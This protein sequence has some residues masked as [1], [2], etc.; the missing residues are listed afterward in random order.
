MT[1]GLASDKFSHCFLYEIR[2]GGQ[3]DKHQILY[4]HISHGIGFSGGR[5]F[6]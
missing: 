5:I 6:G 3:R 2:K 1:T 4:V